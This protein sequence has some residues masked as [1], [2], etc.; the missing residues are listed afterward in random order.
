MQKIN[1]FYVKIQEIN[2][3]YVKIKKLNW[4]PLFKIEDKIKEINNWYKIN[5]RRFN[6]R[7]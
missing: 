3:I 1:W 5:L 2:L 7:N 6:K 4:K